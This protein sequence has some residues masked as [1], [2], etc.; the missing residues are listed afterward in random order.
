VPVTI[1]G[2]GLLGEMLAG[3]TDAGGGEVGDT[4]ADGGGGA[5]GGAAEGLA[6]KAGA[7]LPKRHSAPVSVTTTQVLRSVD[8]IR[9]P[10]LNTRRGR[11]RVLDE[12]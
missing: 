1:D 11:S 5:D 7:A 6:A 12:R 10:S 4:D 3:A 2:A 9:I 8:A